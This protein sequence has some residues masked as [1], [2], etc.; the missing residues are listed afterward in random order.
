MRKLSFSTIP[1][2]GW[3]VEQLIACCKRHGFTGIELRIERDYAIKPDTSDEDALFAGKLF[4]E[5]GISVTDI[6]SSIT[7]N[8]LGE[9]E[10]AQA[11]LSR[12][13]RLAECLGAPGVRIFA[14]TFFKRVGER[15]QI[16][17]KVTLARRIQEACDEGGKR[18]V[19]IWLET[20]NEFSTGE[21]LESILKLVDR[22]NFRIIYDI[23]H[24]YE[25]G[26][27]PEDTLRRIGPK[28]AQVHMKDGEPFEDPDMH[29]WKYTV[30]GEGK[31]P[32]AEIVAGL[33][34]IGYDGYYSLEWETRWRPELKKLN[35]EL[36][37]VLADY[38]RTMERLLAD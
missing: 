4:R 20:H 28:I 37:G 19:G 22:P 5:A 12:H 25:F 24:P 14:G 33:K 23:I 21:A 18:G 34:R 30:T 29:D 9:E 13:I 15:E 1:C 17:D 11:G 36:D 27:S 26:E 6:G 38:V 7:L 31:L 35:L 2:E 8:G 3:S 10:A 32:L 16:S